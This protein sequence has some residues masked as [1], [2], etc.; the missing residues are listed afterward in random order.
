M[1]TGQ[2]IL[3][4][5]DGNLFNNQFLTLIAS[6]EIT[7]KPG[8]HAFPGCTFSARIVDRP[9]VTERKKE[10]TVHVLDVN[11]TMTSSY[12]EKITSLRVCLNFRL[13]IC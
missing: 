10:E 3:V 13:I 12:V 1:V 5:G 2:T 9:D 11:E 8:F 4:K 7:I 6:E